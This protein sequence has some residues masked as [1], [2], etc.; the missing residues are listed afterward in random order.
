M[1]ERDEAI[2]RMRA[3][4]SMAS[5]RED[6][7]PVTG[8]WSYRELCEHQHGWTAVGEHWLQCRICWWCKPKLGKPPRLEKLPAILKGCFLPPLSGKLDLG[9]TYRNAGFVVDEDR[10]SVLSIVRIRVVQHTFTTEPGVRR[11]GVDVRFNALGWKEAGVIME[12][13][14]S[15]LLDVLSSAEPRK[16]KALWRSIQETFGHRWPVPWEAALRKKKEREEKREKAA[17]EKRR[18]ERLGRKVKQ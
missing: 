8:P 9:A 1:G 2:R 5:R 14:L 11:C 16:P 6:P 7:F 17:K 18:A 13:Q 4:H 12:T 15:K 10:R 3:R